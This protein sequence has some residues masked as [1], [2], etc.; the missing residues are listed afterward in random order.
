MASERRQ[1]ILLGALLV[2]LAAVGAYEL[3]PSS[4]A[5]A[6]ATAS[7]RGGRAARADTPQPSAPDVHIDV[8][9][10]EKPKPGSAD[11]DLFAFKPKPLPPAP[12]RPGNQRPGPP[13]PDRSVAPAPPSIPLKFVGYMEAPGGRRIASLTDGRGVIAAREG[14]IVLG[15]YKVW[16]IGV[17]SID[18][19]FLDGHGRQTIRMTGQ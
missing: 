7:N 18:I 15:Q 14:E 16:R 6:Q 11:R 3:W 10:S 17:E 5:A 8:L 4:P 9:S 1:R 13:A 19:S 12:P 2:V